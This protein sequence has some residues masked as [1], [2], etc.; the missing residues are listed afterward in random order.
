LPDEQLKDIAGATALKLNEQP[1]AL[2]P[3]KKLV[4]KKHLRQ[5]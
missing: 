1:D 4:P 2:K 3:K 5:T